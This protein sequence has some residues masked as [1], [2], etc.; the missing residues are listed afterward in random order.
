MSRFVYSIWGLFLFLLFSGCSLQN[1]GIS[2]QT[3][4]D[5]G[6]PFS[7]GL[8]SHI[9]FDAPVHDFGTVVEGERVVAFFNYRNIGPGELVIES[10]ESSCGCTVTEW[11]GK[12]LDPGQG[13]FLKVIFNTAGRYGEQIKVITIR[14]NAKN[15]EVRLK[16][17]ADIITDK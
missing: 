2:E 16:I 14:S 7:T 11:S 4:N 1:S 9:E 10:V 5:S 6:E 3:E 13:S 8:Q 12:P 15:P 17:K